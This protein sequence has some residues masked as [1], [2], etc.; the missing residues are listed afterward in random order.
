M[1]K[2]TTLARDSISAVISHP[3]PAAEYHD[4]LSS[5]FSPARTVHRA[6]HDDRRAR[7]QHKM[8]VAWALVEC[9]GTI[10][11]IVPLFWFPCV[12]PRRI[13]K[14]HLR[15][16]LSQIK[17]AVHVGVK[18]VRCWTPDRGSVDRTL[19]PNFILRP[20]GHP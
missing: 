10:I 3:P 1:S 14:N 11:Y 6:C 8:E 2:N 9:L 16:A 13:N 19:L 12:Q 18:L 17:D 20:P 7:P 15:V 5:R 4:K